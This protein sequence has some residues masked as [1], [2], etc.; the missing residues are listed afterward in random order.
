MKPGPAED[1]RYGF[2]IAT[3]VE[4]AVVVA[5]AYMDGKGDTGMVADNGIV[6]FDTDIDHLIRVAAALAIALA[7]L[8][9]EQRGVLGRV[10]LDVGAAQAREF[11][12]FATR[13]I[14]DVGKIS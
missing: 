4:S 3:G 2:V 12:H 6:H 8:R 13:E 1:G 10:D 7:H 9:I 11:I 14:H 5:P